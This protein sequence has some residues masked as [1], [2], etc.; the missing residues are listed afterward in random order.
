[1]RVIFDIYLPAFQWAVNGRFAFF[2]LFI[3]KCIDRQS[4]RSRDALKIEMPTR[5][6]QQFSG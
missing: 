4:L 5:P 1:M 6:G 3:G 2:S